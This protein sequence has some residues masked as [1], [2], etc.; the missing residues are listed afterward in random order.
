M[1]RTLVAIGLL[2]ASSLALALPAPKDIEAVVNAGHLSQAEAMVREVIREKPDSA[3]AHYELGQ[4]LAGESRTAE[5]RSELLEAQRLDSSLGFASDPQH[6]RDL[7]ARLPTGTT[8]PASSIASGDRPMISAPSSAPPS[9]PLA[10]LLLGAGGLLAAWL[11]F[12]NRLPAPRAPFGGVARNGDI[13]GS[14]TPPDVPAPRP[15]FGVGSALL[16]GAAGM[17]AGYGLA[18]LLEGREGGASSITQG[19]GG[20]SLPGGRTGS[21]PDYGAFDPGA[22]E[23][24]GAGESAGGDDSW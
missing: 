3:K 23:S 2:L 1:T 20:Q 16:G 8:R 17:A 5:A 14:Y 21:Q 6:F 22:G 18:K 4:I 10:Y 9:F 12:R 15:G 7:L 11:L 24:W 19:A 13:P